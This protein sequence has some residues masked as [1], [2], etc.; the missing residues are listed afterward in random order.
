MNRPPFNRLLIAVGGVLI[1]ALFVVEPVWVWANRTASDSGPFASLIPQFGIISVIVLGL[2]GGGIM[3]A[4]GWVFDQFA[5]GS[6]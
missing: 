4:A 2:I 5:G 3:L 6:R 1:L